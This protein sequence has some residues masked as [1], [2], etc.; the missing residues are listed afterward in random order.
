LPVPEIYG[1]VRGSTDG[2]AIDPNGPPCGSSISNECYV[3]FNLLA[4]IP[5]AI[6]VVQLLIDPDR[7]LGEGTPIPARFR[8]SNR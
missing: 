2:R 4:A 5:A 8:G 6:D 3:G 1:S 7:N